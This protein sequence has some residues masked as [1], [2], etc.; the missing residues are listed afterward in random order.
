MNEQVNVHQMTCLALSGAEPETRASEIL[1]EQ[2]KARW[3][4]GDSPDLSDLISK[5]PGIKWRKSTILGL[6]YEEYR[7]RVAQGEVI[8]R[9]EFCGRF[10]S[11]RKSLSRM[12]EVHE[13]FEEHSTLIPVQEGL[14][15]RVGN[16]VLGFLLVEHL[17][18]GA[19]ADVFLGREEAIGQRLVVIKLS[20]DAGLE[21]QTLGQL[22]HPCVV[23]ILSVQTDPKAE[24]T[25]ICM[26]YVGRA[27]LC[28]V[29]DLAFERP[30]NAKQ[31]KT[32]L[33]AIESTGS[34][35]DTPNSSQGVDPILRRGSYIDGILLIAAQ[36]ADAL[37][38]THSKEILH[39][40]LKPSNV[41]LTP[42]G[43]PMLLDFNLSIDAKD[44]R[45]PDGGTL[46]YMSPEQLQASV[47]NRAGTGAEVDER[48]DLF[49][50]GVLIYELLTGHLP[51]DPLEHKLNNEEIAMD[52]LQR[53]RCGVPSLRQSVP[54]LDPHLARLVIKC[55]QFSPR[56]RPLSA[57]EVAKSLQDCLAPRRRVRRWLSSHWILT[58]ITSTIVVAVCSGIACFLAFRPSLDIR[59][60]TKGTEY[61]EQGDH[62]LAIEHLTESINA[63]PLSA[64]AFLA[65]GRSYLLLEQHRQASEDFASA[66]RM[67][68][69]GEAFAGHAFAL[70][71]L[72][73]YREAIE[74]FHSAIAAGFETA[75]VHNDL[76]YAYLSQANF[77]AALRELDVAINISSRLQAAYHNRATVHLK[78][79]TIKQD[80]SAIRG[81]RDIEKAITLGPAT[82]DLYFHGASLCALASDRDP[83]WRELA[84]Q[85][86]AL[87]LA[88]GLDVNVARSDPLLGELYRTLDRKG[89]EPPKNPKASFWGERVVNPLQ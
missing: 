18:S 33:A 69:T 51:F 83:S 13:Y 11:L 64:E 84:R 55:L 88:N 42:S 72:K 66:L 15:P 74:L 10:R 50:F 59:E 9:Q 43:R 82:G 60:Y 21:A 32:I 17:G 28:D 78:L 22:N 81:I 37:A 52:L 76:G 87:A 35:Q 8:D 2:V 29:L 61:L 46:P 56:E 16:T 71:K 53:Q 1:A 6:A 23:P 20:H 75:E 34:L 62:Q 45:R 39:L 12:L 5:H 86:L 68:P 38:H 49:S 44:V 80:D 77:E 79:A 89:I 63:N 24:L 36:L 14:L 31:A 27:T 7:L 73:Y 25:A 57:A 54:E 41:L 67:E 48:S 26:P 3:R 70:T 19:F 65:R 47:A 40:D 30:G 4:R 58:S 85:Y